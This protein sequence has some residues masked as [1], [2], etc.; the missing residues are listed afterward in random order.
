VDGAIGTKQRRW[1]ADYSQE[2]T[3]GPKFQKLMILA[4]LGDLRTQFDLGILPPLVLRCSS[5]LSRA[6]PAL[7]ISLATIHRDW[8]IARAWLVAQLK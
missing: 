7:G 1:T 3:V 4:R 5:G 8:K 6:P 2:K